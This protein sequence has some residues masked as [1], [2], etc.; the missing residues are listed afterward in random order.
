M[1]VSINN[2]PCNDQWEKML[3]QFPKLED[4]IREWSSLSEKCGN[5]GI[6][7]SRLG[8]LYTAARLYD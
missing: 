8:N 7:E 4:R 6:Y 1:A 2:N 5:S 3:K